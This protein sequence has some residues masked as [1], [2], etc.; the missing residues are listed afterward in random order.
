MLV[1]KHHLFASTSHRHGTHRMLVRHAPTLP[2]RRAVCVR[3]EEQKSSQEFGLVGTDVCLDV[4][5]A[6]LRAHCIGTVAHMQPDSWGSVH[7]HV[8]HTVW[9]TVAAC[10]LQHA[11]CDGPQSIKLLLHGVR[12]VWAAVHYSSLGLCGLS[13]QPKQTVAHDLHV[14]THGQ[15]TSAEYASH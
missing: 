1:Q 15:F 14:G 4:L 11:C 12:C 8:H 2:R 13:Q 5:V 6:V 10:S 7:S 9:H 3:A